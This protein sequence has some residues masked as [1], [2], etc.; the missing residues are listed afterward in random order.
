M[1][2]TALS[3]AS[4]RS[5]RPRCCWWIEYY[6]P[7]FGEPPLSGY[8]DAMN[9]A[10]IGF[11]V[12]DVAQRGGIPSLTNLLAY[13]AVFWRVGEFSGWSATRLSGN[14]QLSRRGRLALCGVNGFA[15]RNNENLGTN[16]NR[17]VLQVQSFAGTPP[18]RKSW[19]TA[20]RWA[21]RMN[22][23][24]D[25]TIYEECVGRVYQRHLGHDHAEAQTPCRC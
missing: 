7:L 6:D 25:Y 2:T 15:T 19:T 3:T 4:C 5:C 11:D 14:Q 8:T 20:T 1:T 12:W 16:F 22:V 13:R 17:T 21:K 24:L 23:S 18:C 9:A 10:G